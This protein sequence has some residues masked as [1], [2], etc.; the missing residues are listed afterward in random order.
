MPL[1]RPVVASALSPAV[2][3]AFARRRGALRGAAGVVRARSGVWAVTATVG[4]AATGLAAAAVAAV[5]V[6]VALT[7]DVAATVAA[8]DDPGADCTGIPVAAA[9]TAALVS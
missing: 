3:P 5:V 9:A 8:T 1:S 7:A 4:S 6:A 2:D